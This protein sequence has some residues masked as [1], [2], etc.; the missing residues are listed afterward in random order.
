MRRPLSEP[1]G[2]GRYWVRTSDLFGVNEARYHCANRPKSRL[3][4]AHHI[5]SSA[6]S[7]APIDVITRSALHR[8]PLDCT[9]CNPCNPPGTYVYAASCTPSKSFLRTHRRDHRERIT[10]V[11]FGLHCLQPVQSTRNLRIRSFLHPIG[12]RPCTPGRSAR[13]SLGAAVPQGGP[14]V[15]QWPPPAPQGGP[16]APRWPAPHPSGRRRHIA[17]RPTG[18]SLV[19]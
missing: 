10:Q 3:G 13:T 2:G 7:C 18:M 8:F 1:S 17:R 16:P 14:P 9:A 15:P 4:D 5:P 11:P 12:R 6:P 19:S